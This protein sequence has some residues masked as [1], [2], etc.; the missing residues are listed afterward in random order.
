MTIDE[1]LTSWDNDGINAMQIE[2]SII[3]ITKLHQKYLRELVP[4]R[5]HLRKLEADLRKL[6]LS[7][8]EFLTQGPTQETQRKGWTLPAKG[9]IIKSE[10]EKYLDADSDLNNLHEKIAVA[11]EKVDVLVEIVKMLNARNYKITNIINNRKFES[12]V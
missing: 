11:Q 7:K 4:A 9:V 2:H 12:G 10:A 5:I 3:S 8:W 6:T 1:I